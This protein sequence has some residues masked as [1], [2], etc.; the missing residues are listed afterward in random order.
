MKKRMNKKGRRST[1]ANYVVD[2]LYPVGKDLSQREVKYILMVRKVAKEK[3]LLLDYSAIVSYAS[4]PV[5][6]LHP[7]S[8]VTSKTYKP[9]FLATC[10][11]AVLQPS[12]HSVFHSRDTPI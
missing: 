7:C 1:S 10:L 2:N 11:M 9:A 12:E 6:K 5:W 8:E 4:P 3:E